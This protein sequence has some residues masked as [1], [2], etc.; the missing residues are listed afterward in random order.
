MDHIAYY[1]SL[2][3]E[4]TNARTRIL[5]ASFIQR[6]VPK[7][8]RLKKLKDEL[9]KMSRDKIPFDVSVAKAIAYEECEFIEG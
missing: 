3:P 9:Y 7:E 8:R 2:M 4:A 6:E 1:S 5:F